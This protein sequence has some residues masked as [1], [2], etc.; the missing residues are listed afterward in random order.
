MEKLLTVAGIVGFIV[1]LVSWVRYP[2]IC[3][4]I[5]IVLGALVFFKSGNRKRKG[6]I[7]AVLGLIIGLASIMVDFFYLSIFPPQ[8]VIPVIFWVLH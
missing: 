2:Y 3:G 7:I 1:S 4:I 5:A 6:V 8:A